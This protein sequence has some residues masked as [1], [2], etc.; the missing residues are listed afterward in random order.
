M[1]PASGFVDARGV[2]LHYLDWGGSGAPMVLIHGIGDNPHVFAD[3]AGKLS[4]DLRLVAY[5]RRGHGR[6]DAPSGPYDLDAYVDDLL[7]VTDGLRLDRPHLLGWSMGGNE[8]TAYAGRHPDRVGRLCYLEAGYDWSDETFLP[9]FGQVLADEAP[10][11]ANLASLDAYR[12]WFRA[13]WF[14]GMPWTETLEA[15][16]REAVRLD[17]E[18]KV[19]PVPDATTFEALFASLCAPPRDYTRVEAPALALY[20]PR[21]FPEAPGSPARRARFDRFEDEVMS[22]FRPASRQRIARELRSVE[23][24]ECPGTTHMSIGVERPDALARAIV[25]FV[26]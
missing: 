9:A 3:L 24:R 26:V 14:G 12:D 13:T 20:A 16:L 2:R 22:V 11:E 4:G 21:F 10:A 6:S 19:H 7:A 5:A 15:Y 23:I 1:V 8:I 25:N 18:G 17:A